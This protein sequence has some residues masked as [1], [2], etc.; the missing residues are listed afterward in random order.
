MACCGIG[1]SSVALFKM[2][3][4]TGRV[5]CVEAVGKFEDILVR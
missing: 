2:Q 3:W 4:E 5:G 1:K